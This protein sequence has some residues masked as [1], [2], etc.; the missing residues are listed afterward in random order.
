VNDG[1]QLR[2]LERLATEQAEGFRGTLMQTPIV[3]QG[4]I[5]G[6]TT[7]ELNEPVSPFAGP[8][9]VVVHPSVAPDDQRSLAEFVKNLPGGSRS[10]DEIDAQIHAEHD[11]WE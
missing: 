1:Q 5:A 7:I 10:K 3:V 2:L 4:R 8:V 6:P 11:C 9:E